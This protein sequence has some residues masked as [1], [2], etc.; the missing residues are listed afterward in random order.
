MLSQKSDIPLFIDLYTE[1]VYFV[2]E[3]SIWC[4]CFGKVLI[5]NGNSSSGKTTLSRYL[6]KFGFN[7]ISLDDL[8]TAAYFDYIKNRF[9]NQI[10]LIEQFVKNDDLRRIISG[11]TPDANQYT[12]EEFD[13][14]YR[15]QQDIYIVHKTQ[16]IVWKPVSL[17]EKFNNLYHQAKAFIFSGRSVIIDLVVPGND[18]DLLIYTFGYYPMTVIIL[19]NSLEDNLG[20]CFHRNELSKKTGQIDF[21]YPLDIMLGYQEFYKFAPKMDVCKS[22]WVIEKINK[23]R[24]IKALYHAIRHQLYL[25]N[26]LE[27]LLTIPH[28]YN[29]N[30]IANLG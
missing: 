2:K 1:Q 8:V 7:L 28:K 13:F 19:Y 29:K 11:Y 20:K 25:S 18:I 24:L 27:H 14:I 17:A 21:R 16:H 30:G 10:N 9:C 4:K 5:L 23:A 3:W 26:T 15:L 6:S 22:D 12:N